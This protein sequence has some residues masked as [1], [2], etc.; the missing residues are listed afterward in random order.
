MSHRVP[1]VLAASVFVALIL[2]LGV[3]PAAAQSSPPVK[4]WSLPA[5]QLVEPK[6][7]AHVGR[8]PETAAAAAELAKTYAAKIDEYRTRAAADIS[9][10]ET[11]REELRKSGFQAGTRKAWEAWFER[12]RALYK[13]VEAIIDEYASELDKL[14][15]PSGSS[16]PGAAVGGGTTPGVAT[17]APVTTVVPLPP[18]GSTGAVLPG[19]ALPPPGSRP[20]PGGSAGPGATVPAIVTPGGLGLGSGPGGPWATA[21]QVQ[22]MLGNLPPVPT[23]DA[24]KQLADA[25]R[26]RP[27]FASKPGEVDK[28]LR[29]FTDRL[30]RARSHSQGAVDRVAEAVRII[31]TKPSSVRAADLPLIR[32]SYLDVVTPLTKLV[33]DFESE[34]RN[35]G[36]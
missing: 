36:G 26:N 35:K 6:L 18:A 34:L 2:G 27:N 30:D 17:P 7:N 8:K 4:W 23:E 9:R 24:L 31:R 12:N 5:A 25:A 19:P 22:E 10:H 1:A 33:A 29:K 3:R 15:G 16:G 14:S 28:M 21:Y 13:P 11:E 32:D 20:L